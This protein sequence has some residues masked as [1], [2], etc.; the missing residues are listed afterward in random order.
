M[1]EENQQIQ[2]SL[3][4]EYMVAESKWR[5]FQGLRYAVLASIFPL[6]TTLITLYQVNFTALRD[7]EGLGIG[8]LWLVC[9]IGAVSLGGIYILQRRLG[10]AYVTCSRRC[11]RIEQLL[12]IED[13]VF[14][15]LEQQS[16][17][18]RNTQ[19]LFLGIILVAIGFL[20]VYLALAPIYK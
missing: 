14:R 5:F 12:Q 4:A 16:V 15:T 6:Y 1:A 10:N 8:F 3:R 7:S 13:G 18:G 17:Y 9:F 19:R 11:A 2:E 20:W